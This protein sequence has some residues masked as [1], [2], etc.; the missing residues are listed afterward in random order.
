MCCEIQTIWLYIR[1]RRVSDADVISTDLILFELSA[2]WLAIGR[3]HGE[4]GRFTA[5][6]LLG[7]RYD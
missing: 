3:N 6:D 4:L 1:Q 5:H 2:L 7:R